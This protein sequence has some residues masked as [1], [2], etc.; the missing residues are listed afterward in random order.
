MCYMYHTLPSINIPYSR[1]LMPRAFKLGKSWSGGWA[2][3]WEGAFM[4]GGRGAFREG[5]GCLGG[6]GRV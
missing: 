4:G 3:M 1:G 6:G 2:F 5:G